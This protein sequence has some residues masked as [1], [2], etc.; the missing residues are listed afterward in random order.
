[1]SF[2]N[3]P[4]IKVLG[5]EIEYLKTERG[6]SDLQPAK[7]RRKTTACRVA[8]G[9]HALKEWPE[10]GWRVRP[11]GVWPVFDRQLGWWR[12]CCSKRK[13]NRENRLLCGCV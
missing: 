4:Q 10:R 7:K 3:D 9:V 1:M 6:C 13:G 11:W 5:S 8:C 12:R 2:K